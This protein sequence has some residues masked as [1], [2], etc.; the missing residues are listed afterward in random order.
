[1]PTNETIWEIEPHT[2]AKHQMLREYL[3][4]WFPIMGSFNG[5]IVYIDGFAGPGEYKEGEPGS[6]IVAIETLIHH[7]QPPKSEVAFVF[8]EKDPARHAHLRAKLEATTFAARVRWQS[9]C[10]E[11][12]EA[13][14]SL[15]NMLD[16]QNQLLAPTFAFIDPFGFSG[17]PM[18]VI[19]RIMRNPRC[20]VLVNV[21]YQHLNRFLTHPDQADNFTALFDSDRWRGATALSTPR[22]RHAYL[23]DLY[24]NQLLANGCRYVWDF[25]MIDS[26][27]QP[28]YHLFFGT[29]G[30]RGLERMKDAMWKVDPGAGLR[31]SD[32]TDRNQ[33]VVLGG[34]PNFEQLQAMLMAEFQSRT[35][36]IEEI[37]EYVLV[38]TPFRKGHIKQRT[39][40]PLE[41]DGRIQTDSAKAC[42]YKEGTRITFLR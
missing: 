21:M 19:A 17:T 20:E 40:A 24:R 38:S 3:K 13:L 22:E 28:L 30:L 4:A 34:E 5:R 12:D 10:A 33:L 7:K 15:L 35:V 2:E 9:I 8:I 23:V 42:S 26:Q 32:R 27:N 16:E 25:E 11:F 14:H 41:R 31:F 36:T 29:R 18:S 6:P 37:Q 39:L 1:M